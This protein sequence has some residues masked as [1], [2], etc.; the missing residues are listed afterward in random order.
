M[1]IGEH[2][3]IGN[4]HPLIPNPGR[5]RWQFWKPRKIVDKSRLAVFK[6]VSTTTI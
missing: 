5:K 3:T 4:V 6:V 2:F 1:V